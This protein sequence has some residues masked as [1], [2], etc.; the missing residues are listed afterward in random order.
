MTHIPVFFTPRMV[1]SFKSFSPSAAKP[2]KVVE[3]W[4]RQFPITVV[5]PKPV[6]SGAFVRVH[7]PQ[8]VQDILTCKINNGFEN[9]SPEVAA[10]LFYTSGAMLSAAK[11][12][13]A[14]GGAAA[15]PCSGFHHAEYRKAMGFCTFNGLMV[16]AAALHDTGKIKRIGILDLDCHYGNGTDD[17]I[18]ELGAKDW[19]RHFTGGGHFKRPEQA[20]E[21]F[22]VLPSVLSQMGDCDIVLYQAGAD[23]H[24][25]DPGA[26]EYGGWLTTE[27]LRKRDA[28]VFDA[29]AACK[30]PVA[31]NLAGGY[32][33]EPDGSIPK[34]LEIHD[35]TMRECVR[36]FG[37]S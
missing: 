19:V 10:S 15:A 2:E 20:P 9:R 1:A 29:L 7:D 34:V 16:T 4:K 37:G 21:F 36:V 8:F 11:H 28:M 24:V 18:R 22:N 26:S 5:E 35:N 27:E 31:W 25:D 23:P 6:T 33:V 12:V 13:L 3:S 17:I 32:Q 30:V 14:S